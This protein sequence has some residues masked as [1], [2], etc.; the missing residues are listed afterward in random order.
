MAIASVQDRFCLALNDRA[1]V[2]ARFWGDSHDQAASPGSI[3]QPQRRQGI[4]RC[5]YRRQQ[6]LRNLGV[7]VNET[8]V[9]SI[10]SLGSGSVS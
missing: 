3:Q 10:I 1:I 6:S 2:V 9:G 7:F 8:A 4:R 5:A